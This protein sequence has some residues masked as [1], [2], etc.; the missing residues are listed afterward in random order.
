M[1]ELLLY[2]QVPAPRHDQV[3]KILAGVAALQPRRLLARHIIYKPQ[4][5]PDEPGSHL[6]RGGTQAIGG[7]NHKQ[8][9]AKDL[10]YSQLVQKLSEE[11]LNRSGPQPSNGSSSTGGTG[12]GAEP[13]W[14]I[15]FQDVPDTGDRG[16]SIRM[17]TSTGIL[18][19]DPHAYMLSN[20]PNQFMS[21]YYVEGHQI[22][23]GNVVVFLHRVLHDSSGTSPKA[24]LPKF[25][26]LKPFDPSGAYILEA[27]VQV[28]E[29]N[30]TNVLEAGVD[31]LKR[32][33]SQMKGCVELSV[34][35]RLSLDT[36]VKYKA[37]APSS[38]KAQPGAR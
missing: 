3:L 28:Q 14:T 37:A 6:R 20:G 13:K 2:G 4:R 16:V 1:H 8:P 32:F 18:S 29:F 22:V 31:E 33:Q 23:H 36:R 5:A 25:T 34:P 7:K 11:D 24:N 35:D 26:E 19:G 30:N 17:T 38:K 15:E 9:V 10:Y 12:S 21:E 27:K